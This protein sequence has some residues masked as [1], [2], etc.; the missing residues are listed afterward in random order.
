MSNELATP[1][2][3]PNITYDKYMAT[4]GEEE[5]VAGIRNEM[6][7]VIEKLALQHTDW[8]FEAYRGTFKEGIGTIITGFEVYTNHILLGRVYTFIKYGASNSSYSFAMTNK[9][10]RNN[11][12][13]GDS[14]RTT[15]PKTAIKLINKNFVISSDA[16]VFD[17]AMDEAKARFDNILE[18][19]NR[20]VRVSW[21]NEMST[22]RD[23]A[24]TY[25]EMFT[26]GLEKEAKNMM[27][28]LLDKTN[29]SSNLHAFSDDIVAS[30]TYNIVIRG[31]KFIVQH[32]SKTNIFGA[33][34]LSEHV[35]R[36]LGLLKLV[37]DNT[38]L[39]NVGFRFTKDS[40]ILESDQNVN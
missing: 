20:E 4:C 3:L 19:K 26:S 9:R 8:R 22:L 15:K 32:N 17:E 2:N 21:D 34:E 38:Y 13:R 31:D 30:K 16:E 6:H 27:N 28:K 18:F 33:H 1:L 39:K 37:E 23:F 14:I 12:L 5:T 10:I 25:W 40:F 35:N 24:F 7:P 11:L 29:E 36:N